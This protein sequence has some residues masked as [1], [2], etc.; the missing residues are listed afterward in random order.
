MRY[1][2]AGKDGS[3][4]RCEDWLWMLANFTELS[5]ARPQK[6]LL[7]ASLNDDSC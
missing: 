7:K 2:P 6:K 5:S 4:L 1:L 3:V